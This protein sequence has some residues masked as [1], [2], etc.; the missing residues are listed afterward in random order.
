MGAQVQSDTIFQRLYL[1]FIGPFP[2]SKSGN[3]GILI[4]LDHF[5]KFTFLKAVKKFNTKV[6]IS[7]LRDEIF[8]CFGVPETVVSDNGTQL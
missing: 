8:S 6:I 3:I 4:I 1:D 7:I 2:R 5:S